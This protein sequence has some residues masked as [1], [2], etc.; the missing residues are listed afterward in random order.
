M[1]QLQR[2][3]QTY[4]GMGGW[5]LEPFNKL[6]YPPKPKKEFR[7]LEYYSQFFDC[8]EINA[9]FHTTSFTPVHARR[10][11]ADV[12]GNSNFMFTVK[13]FQGFTHTLDATMEDVRSVQKL[14]DVLA[15]AG[16]LGGV[17]M[18][19]PYNFT[20]LSERRKYLMQFS[21]VFKPYRV[22]VEMRHN[23]WNSPLMYNY[24]Q[25]NRLHLVNV[26]LPQVKQN[27]PFNAQA[28]NGAA[29]FRMMGRNPA[30]GEHTGSE[31]NNYLYNEREL[32]HLSYYV[33]K[34]KANGNTVF[35]VFHNEPEANSL[36]NGFQLRHLTR[37]KHRVLVPQNFV[38]N[39]PA[40]KS[41]SA[42]VN[43]HHPLFAGV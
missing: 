3:H 41:I 36:K 43:I 39:F 42:E 28:W 18:Q 4:I 40:L 8:V 22:F 31:R 7:K 11:I 5:E 1:I 38:N 15:S 30:Y 35:V 33:E 25:E 20:N 14:L 24:F 23:S 26:D 19:F 32:E 6:F 21:K 2:Q 12:S 17:L 37:H 29:Y 9:T 34:V 27:M 16:K 10:W 13:L